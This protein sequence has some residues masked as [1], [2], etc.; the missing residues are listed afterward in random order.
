MRYREVDLN[1]RRAAEILLDRFTFGARPGDVERLLDQG[2]DTWWASQLEGSRPGADLERALAKL[3]ATGMTQAEVA[4]TYPG[5]SMVSAHARR[6]HDILPPRDEPVMDFSI[7]RER[8]ERF[9]E[10]QGFERDEEVL[11]PQIRGQKLLH[12][13]LSESQLREVLTDLWQGHFHAGLSSFDARLWLISFEQSALRPHALGRF[14]SL[15]AAAMRHPVMLEHLKRA[16]LPATLTPGESLMA[17]RIE[18]LRSDPSRD[19]DDTLDLLR[20]AESTL[21][22]LDEERDLI[23]AREFWAAS[24]PNEELA[25][26]LLTLYTLGSRAAHS[27][28]DVRDVARVLTGWTAHPRGATVQW[29]AQDFAPLRP[30]GFVAERGLL[31]RAD[32]HDAGA[33]RILGRDYGPGGGIEEGEQ[34]LA[35]LAARPETARHIATKLTA[36]FASEDVPERI[37]AP[38]ADRFESSGG[39]LGE[40]LSVLVDLPEFWEVARRRAKVKSPFEYTV[41]TLR[42]LGAEV[43]ASEQLC[44]WCARMGEPLYGFLEST[45]YPES[46]AY[47]LDPAAVLQRLRFARALASGEL[48]GVRLP[49]RESS[50][51]GGSSSAD[52]RF[53]RIAS[54]AF[55]SR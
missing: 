7:I 38:L 2:L 5:F 10:E 47:W 55:Q 23:L 43:D 24:G 27:D 44:A 1:D 11:F 36:R 13:L 42:A 21:A 48:R 28:A 32:Q 46:G 18:G 8:L 40:T 3:P 52:A 16:A 31:F 6:Y 26:T 53:A 37:V 19:A 41:S 14:G 33:K 4:A 20:T 35:Q 17:Q 51:P 34:L 25:R 12:A 22:A 29:F 50:D 54:P 45:G 9:A 30:L 49:S 15:L 39:D